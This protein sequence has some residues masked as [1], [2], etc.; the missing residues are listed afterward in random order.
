MSGTF[1]DS[2]Y[3]ALFRKISRLE[4][5]EYPDYEDSNE[6]IQ[7]FYAEWGSFASRLSFAWVQNDVDLL[8]VDRKVRRVIEQENAKARKNARKEYNESV[9][10]FSEFVKRRDPRYQQWYASKK[11]EEK[12]EADRLSALK[13]ERELEKKKKGFKDVKPLETDKADL[14]NTEDTVDFIEEEHDVWYCPAC[15]KYFKS[16]GSFNN[17]EKSKKHIKNVELMKQMLLLEDEDFCCISDNDVSDVTQVSNVA[18]GQKTTC[19]ANDSEENVEEGDLVQRNYSSKKSGQNFLEENTDIQKHRQE[20]DAQ[21]KKEVQIKNKKS[22]RRAVERK[23]SEKLGIG[24]D[25]GKKSCSIC[26]AEFESRNQL[27]AHIRDTGH[28]ALKT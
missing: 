6:P 4:N 25:I 10:F 11:E 1:D 3:A 22:R 9:R 28:A 21:E 2:A 27:F 14:E 5:D 23:K 19:R 13:M 18:D 15:E 8:K 12:R 26:K 17:H 24:S 16:K 7:V 20:H